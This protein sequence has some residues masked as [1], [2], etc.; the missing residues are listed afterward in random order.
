MA[1]AICG[2]SHR[3]VVSV[4]EERWDLPVVD[5][6]VGPLLGAVV[7]DLSEQNLGQELAMLC[8][9]DGVLLRRE[10]FPEGRAEMRW[11]SASTLARQMGAQDSGGIGETPEQSISGPTTITAL[12]ALDELSAAF[13]RTNEQSEL[14]DLCVQ[15]LAKLYDRCVMLHGDGAGM[16]I[17]PRGVLL[18]T[19]DRLNVVAQSTSSDIFAPCGEAYEDDLGR[20]PVVVL[21]PLSKQV[22]V[23]IGWNDDRVQARPMAAMLIHRL[24]RIAC[25]Q[26]D[27]EVSS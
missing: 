19:T 8:A 15:A 13:L 3:L 22:V 25:A 1:L 4:G 10:R 9:L 14:L 18:G 16:W 6:R 20:P 23:A 7:G 21:L 26:Y 24:Y 11:I 27:G 12:D 5:G 2:G 17:G